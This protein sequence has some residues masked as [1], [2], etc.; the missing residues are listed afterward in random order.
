MTDRTHSSGTRSA[1][2]RRS[3]ALVGMVAAALLV[4]LAQADAQD[5]NGTRQPDLRCLSSQPGHCLPEAMNPA[6][7]HR[8][9]CATCHDLWKQPTLAHARQSCTGAGCHTAPE[10]ASAFHRGLSAERLHD[11]IS[12]HPAHDVRIPG[13]GANC[14]FCHTA[15]GAQPAANGAPRGVRRPVTAAVTFEHQRHA[16]LTCT[17]CHPSG[18]THGVVGPTRIQDCRSCHHR[19][20]QALA[21]TDCHSGSE[22]TFAR[23]IVRTFNIRLGSLNRPTRELTFDH[24]AHTRVECSACHVGAGASRKAQADCSSCHAQHHAGN[25]SCTS[26]HVTPA[27]GVHDREVHLGCGGAGCHDQALPAIQAAPRVRNLCVTC[28]TTRVTHRVGLNCADCHRLPAARTQP[29]RL[30]RSNR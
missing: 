28:H 23:R 30:S 18:A 6:E 15:G 19:D 5:G 10:T 25:V 16:R 11:C 20:R 17:D 26:C 29:A 2:P 7:P 9:V 8:A 1:R 14:N 21:C 22:V 13:G 27:S 4:A 12:C 24:G 3:L